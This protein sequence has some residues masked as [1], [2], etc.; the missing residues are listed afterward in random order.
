MIIYSFITSWLTMVGKSSQ[1]KKGAH[2][3][4]EMHRNK[5]TRK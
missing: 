3:N 1:C 4:E 5:K 2:S